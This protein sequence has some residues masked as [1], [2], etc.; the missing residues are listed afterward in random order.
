M[1]FIVDLDHQ[2]S[3]SGDLDPLRHTVVERLESDDPLD[4]QGS[5]LGSKDGHGHAAHCPLVAAHLVQGDSDALDVSA[6]DLSCDLGQATHEFVLLL[7][8]PA[9]E[10][11]DLNE[12]HGSS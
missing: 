4:G 9:L 5:A 12:R 3:G 6:D 7:D 10:H 2:E 1:G 11:G 8:R